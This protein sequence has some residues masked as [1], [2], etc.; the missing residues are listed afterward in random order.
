MAAHYVAWRRTRLVIIKNECH[1]NII[2]DRLQGCLRH[3]IACIDIER[4]YVLYGVTQ[5]LAFLT[6]F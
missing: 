4:F 2:V 6:V 1:S 5:H 3:Q